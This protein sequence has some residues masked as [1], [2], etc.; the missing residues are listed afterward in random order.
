MERVHDDET[1]N[2]LCGSGK[3]GQ[4]ARDAAGHTILLLDAAEAY[5]RE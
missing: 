2:D 4:E 5:H 3:C 1:A